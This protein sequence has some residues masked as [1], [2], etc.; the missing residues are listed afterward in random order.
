MSDDGPRLFLITPPVADAGRFA[1]LLETAVQA[2]DIACILLRVEGDATTTIKT[3][4][5]IAQRRGI[6]VLVENEARLAARAAAD[7]VHVDRGVDALAEAIEALRPKKIVGVGNLID[8]DAAMIAGEAGADYL[9]FGGPE[10]GQHHDEVAERIAWWASIF[11]VPCVGYAD[12]PDRAGAI[13]E[14]GAEFVALC[15][16]LWDDPAAI[17][18][19][20]RDVTRAIAPTGE[21]V[22]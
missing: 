21:A 4:A 14:A 20:L 18:P 7:G 12:H 13:A 9:M 8:R 11:N 10:L 6:A 22:G 15:A 3:L 5:P 16:G 17:G 1:P 19:I 2:A